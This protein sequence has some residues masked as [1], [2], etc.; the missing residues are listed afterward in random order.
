MTSIT[1]LN[2]ATGLRAD[3]KKNELGQLSFRAGLA[4]NSFLKLQD[5]IKE[6]T[7]GILSINEEKPI[8]ENAK[9]FDDTK[10][11]N[12]N[13]KMPGNKSTKFPKNKNS[14]KKG[15]KQPKKKKVNNNKNNEKALLG[16]K[17]FPK[18]YA[19][20]GAN[21]REALRQAKRDHNIPMGNQHINTK[22]NQQIN[23]NKRGQE[24]PGKVYKF[25][26]VNNKE[27]IIRDDSNGHD[28]GNEYIL[29]KHFN[30]GDKHYF[31]K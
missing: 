8:N 6:M 14:Q 28:F 5:N 10:L 2:I 9:P 21:H 22:K 30:V 11:E 24:Q 17:R 31:Y 27:I 4:L 23:Y 16:K 19:R 20:E 7:E 12:K 15:Q 18:N 3:L 13:S 1:E 26:D 25:K 29:P